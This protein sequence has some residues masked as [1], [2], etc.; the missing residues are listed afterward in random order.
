M[1]LRWRFEISPSR[2]RAGWRR[3]DRGGE[4]TRTAQAWALQRAE[5]RAS[6]DASSGRDVAGGIGTNP[7]SCARRLDLSEGPGLHV[8]VNASAEPRSADRTHAIAEALPARL[9]ERLRL[10]ELVATPRSSVNLTRGA[11]TPASASPPSTRSSSST[12]ASSRRT[13]C[14]FREGPPHRD[15]GLDRDPAPLLE[16]ARPAAPRRRGANSSTKAGQ[17]SADRDG[18]RAAASTSASAGSRVLAFCIVAY[19]EPE[20]HPQRYAMKRVNT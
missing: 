13:S 19:G 3:S 16:L 11:A 15:Q 4:P 20:V 2:S 1:T 10:R 14:C 5:F 17:C 12:I 8:N 7:T 18:S 6:S 9:L